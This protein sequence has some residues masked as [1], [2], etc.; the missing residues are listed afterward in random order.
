MYTTEKYRSVLN[1][2]RAKTCEMV[3][4]LEKE[5]KQGEMRSLCILYN[6]TEFSRKTISRTT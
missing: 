5:R 1:D 6:I 2:I 4:F 3:Y